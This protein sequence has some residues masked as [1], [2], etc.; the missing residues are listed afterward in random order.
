MKKIAILVAIALALG[1]LLT[2]YA[3]PVKFELE[4]GT[5]PPGLNSPEI[6]GNET[7]FVIINHTDEGTTVLQFQLRGL[8]PDFDYYVYYAMWDAHNNLITPSPYP[9]FGPM[10]VNKFGFGHFHMEIPEI[11]VSKYVVGICDVNPCLLKNNTVMIVKVG[12]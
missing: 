10:K 12:F 4:R 9:T 1:I 3:N 11:T 5:P 2:A 6:N 8:T 7:G